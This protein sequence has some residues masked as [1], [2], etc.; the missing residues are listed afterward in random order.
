MPVGL[1]ILSTPAHLDVQPLKSKHRKKHIPLAFSRQWGF[2][3]VCRDTFE[4]EV[5][6]MGQYWP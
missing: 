1:I 6:E 3:W 4:L 2:L 5:A